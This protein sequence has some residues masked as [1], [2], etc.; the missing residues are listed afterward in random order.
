VCLAVSYDTEYTHQLKRKG[1]YLP[2]AQL[3]GFA[4]KAGG[5]AKALPMATYLSLSY[6]Y[7]RL[8][9]PHS[10]LHLS[11][12]THAGYEALLIGTKAKVEA[13]NCTEWQ[14]NHYPW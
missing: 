3:S 12:L 7:G 14:I 11:M 5:E 1:P 6:K 13:R 2:P 10:P 8:V 9:R 4:I